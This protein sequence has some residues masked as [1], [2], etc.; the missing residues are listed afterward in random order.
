M[1]TVNLRGVPADLVQMK[2]WEL[3]IGYERDVPISR[4]F[5][6][7]CRL[8][9]VQRFL[10]RRLIKSDGDSVVLRTKPDLL[11]RGMLPDQSGHARPRA[12]AWFRGAAIWESILLHS[13]L[14][15]AIPKSSYQ[16]LRFALHFLAACRRAGAKNDRS[17]ANE[18]KRGRG[19]HSVSASGDKKCAVIRNLRKEVPRVA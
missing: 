18:D 17:L 13:K 10:R 19:T 12:A 14:F 9:L 7:D 3:A 15:P 5:P 6:A 1:I 8:D 16:H 2:R 11:D 4:Q